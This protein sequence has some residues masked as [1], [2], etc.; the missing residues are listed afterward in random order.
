MGFNRSSRGSVKTMTTINDSGP[1]QL[2]SDP[3]YA[4]VATLNRDGSIHQTVVW[5]SA[6]G[7]DI[8]VNSAVGRIWPTNLERDPE[9]SVLV[10]EAG[11]PYHFVEI[12][13]RATASRED[14][15]E[16]INALA[17]K[18]IGQDEYPYRQPGEQRIK[19]RVTPDH[20]RYVKQ[21]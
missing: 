11:D 19:F 6:E 2:L 13:G 15:D 12:R 3:N 7:D 20:V 14:A 16:H 21:G 8:A 10:Q 9:I 17:K 4:V 1:Q 5:V 18:Y